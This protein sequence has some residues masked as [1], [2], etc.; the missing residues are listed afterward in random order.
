MKI[1]KLTDPS[2]K[3]VLVPRVFP[4][5]GDTLVV[6]LR[7]EIKNTYSDVEHSWSYENNYLT[8][9]LEDSDFFTVNTKYELEVIRNYNTIYKGKIYFTDAESIQDFKLSTI[10]NKKIKF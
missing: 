10:T 7:N 5:E 8:I 9:A 1:L 6:R 2:K 4:N 3:V